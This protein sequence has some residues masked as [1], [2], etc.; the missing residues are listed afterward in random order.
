MGTDILGATSH[1]R[2]SRADNSERANHRTHVYEY[3]A[4][5]S[6]TRNPLSVRGRDRS[7]YRNEMA[8]TALGAGGLNYLD[9]PDEDLPPYSLEDVATLAWHTTPFYYTSIDRAGRG[10]KSTALYFRLPTDAQS[11]AAASS[12]DAV[13]AVDLQPCMCSERGDCTC[14]RRGPVMFHAEHT[15]GSLN[16]YR[17]ARSDDLVAR[18]RQKRVLQ[19]KK[20]MVEDGS[21]ANW[22]VIERE[23][24]RTTVTPTHARR[25]RSP[26]NIVCI[27]EGADFKIISE[28]N[29]HQ[30]AVHTSDRRLRILNVSLSC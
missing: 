2:L 4:R 26:W 3:I 12:Q 10:E 13:A 29:R 7:C 15:T 21:G 24:I 23:G 19:R 6:G 9:S 14:N 8:P 16:L 28:P 5:G 27:R 30:I 25:S 11:N 22:A 18:V 17:T 20:W 1:Y